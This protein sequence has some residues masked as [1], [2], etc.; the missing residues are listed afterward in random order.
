MRNLSNFCYGWDIFMNT[1]VFNINKMCEEYYA[2]CYSQNDNLY[3]NTPKLMRLLVT[4]INN[5]C[6][7]WQFMFNDSISL[8]STKEAMCF[9]DH[10]TYKMNK[11]IQNKNKTNMIL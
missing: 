7:F 6:F 1:I 8:S 5:F 2:V 11:T 4:F 10:Y 3:L 9:V